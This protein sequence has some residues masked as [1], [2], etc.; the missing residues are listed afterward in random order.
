M[1]CDRGVLEQRGLLRRTYRGVYPLRL[2]PPDP[3]VTDVRD[4]ALEVSR[5]R[6]LLGHHSKFGASS[7]CRF[8][9]VGDFEAIV[10]DTG[11]P[12][13]GAHRCALLGSRVFRV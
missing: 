7:F 12:S 3:V 8:A 1:A 6:V 9:E 4:E 5:R 13:T 10:T 11:L 2:D